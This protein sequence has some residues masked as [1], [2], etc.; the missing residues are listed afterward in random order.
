MCVW[1]GCLLNAGSCKKSEAA[2]LR[3]SQLPILELEFSMAVNFSERGGHRGRELRI[4]TALS[5]MQTSLQGHRNEGWSCVSES[6]RVG[7]CRQHTCVSSLWPVN[8]QRRK[9]LPTN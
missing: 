8:T 5:L 3:G 6:T 1:G 9:T 7:D 4:F 2:G